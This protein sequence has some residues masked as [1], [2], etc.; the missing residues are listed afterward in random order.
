M[1]RHPTR[2]RFGVIAGQVSNPDG[3]MVR[4]L[5]TKTAPRRERERQGGSPDSAAASPPF[6]DS[7]NWNSF[8]DTPRGRLQRELAAYG[9]HVETVRVILRRH[10][11]RRLKEPS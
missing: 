11:T 9:T 3:T 7:Y 6:K 2:C 10:A 8:V 4:L 1:S 5:G